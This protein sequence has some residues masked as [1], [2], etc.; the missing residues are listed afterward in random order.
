LLEDRDGGIELGD[1]CGDGGAF[2]FLL[3]TLTI[4]RRELGREFRGLAHQ[5][6]A[7]HRNEARWR[8]RG[9]MKLGCGIGIAD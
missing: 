2:G 4:E 8:G 7:L 3:R 9:R 1:R 6:L 5:E